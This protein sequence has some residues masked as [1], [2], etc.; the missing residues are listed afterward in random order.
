[1]PARQWLFIVAS[2][3]CFTMLVFGKSIEF[4]DPVAKRNVRDGQPVNATPGDDVTFSPPKEV[5]IML[6]VKQTE[7]KA[8]LQAQVSFEADHPGVSLIV[9]TVPEQEAYELFKKKSR[10]GEA[11]DVMLL[12]SDWVN[13]FA[14][15][16]YLL[17]L[18]EYFTTEQQLMQLDG[19]LAQ[20]K[21][22]G[23][24]WGVP[25]DVDPY[26]LV[27]QPERLK[28]WAE[29]RVPT[30]PEELLAAHMAL[31]KPEEGRYGLVLPPKDAYTFLSWL[32]A[33]GGGTDDPAGAE[34]PRWD[35]PVNAELL[36][37]FFPAAAG[38]GRSD[39][40]KGD[41]TRPLAATAPPAVASWMPA[42]ESLAQPWEELRQGRWAMTVAPLSEYRS[43]GEYALAWSRLPAV[44]EAKG[45]GGLLR[46]RSFVIASRSAHAREAYEWIRE[47]TSPESAVHLWSAGAPAPAQLEAYGADRVPQEPLFRE[48]VQAIDQGRTLAPAPNWPR[49]RSLLESE[50]ETWWQ[51]N[52]PAAEWLRQLQRKWTEPGS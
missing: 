50:L 37:R 12:Q 45:G 42:A 39:G 19:L 22:N 9:E 20:S 34:P 7:L 3:L 40:T 52:A 17:P 2:F 5:R 29:G 27:Y 26:V 48:M 35:R 4:A 28:E 51:G 25:K 13:E 23:Y 21:W 8:L 18:D 49:K 43:R 41:A 38:E 36:T 32:C 44:G 46:G 16:G 47:V 24:I 30:T 33:S 15:L 10:L 31:S 11:P 6:P 1:M 14:A